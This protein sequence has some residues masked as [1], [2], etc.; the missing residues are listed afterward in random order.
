VKELRDFDRCGFTSS[1]HTEKG[2]IQNYFC[3]TEIIGDPQKGADAARRTADEVER[4]LAGWSRTTRPDSANIYFFS[5]DGF[6]RVRVS[7]ND[8]LGDAPQRVT[9][10]VGP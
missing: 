1:D 4:S 2:G 5:K 8:T 9:L 7:Y 6:P 10:L 3:D